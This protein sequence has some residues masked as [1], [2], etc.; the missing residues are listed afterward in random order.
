MSRLIADRSDIDLGLFGRGRRQLAGRGFRFGDGQCPRLLAPLD[1]PLD[2]QPPARHQHFAHGDAVN[3]ECTEDDDD[4]KQQAIA[5]LRGAIVVAP[6]RKAGDGERQQR[7]DRVP[8][9]PRH[10][11]GMRRRQ[12]LGD[13]AASRVDDARDVERHRNAA[14]KERK[15]PETV[16]QALQAAGVDHSEDE[17]DRRD[18]VLQPDGVLVER[19]A[20]ALA[21]AKVR[22]EQP[23]RDADELDQAQ[24]EQ[25]GRH[26]QQADTDAHREIGRERRLNQEPAGIAEQ[27]RRLDRQQHRDQQRLGGAQVVVGGIATDGIGDGR[28]TLEHAARERDEHAEGDQHEC[29][30]DR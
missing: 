6:Q 22:R 29:G 14:G 2:L 15:A 16:A 8:D 26:G 18:D 17:G 3:K 12:A 30:R 11:Q 27:Q 24:E 21:P 20:R 4:G 19:G 25:K 7:N 13:D 28:Q 23:I 9:H 1:R 10:P 5:D